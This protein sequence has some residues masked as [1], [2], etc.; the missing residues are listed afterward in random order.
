LKI[1]GQQHGQMRSTGAVLLRA[2]M[3]RSGLALALA[4]LLVPVAV[5]ASSG[6]AGQPAPDFALKNSAGTNLRLS[7]Y[8]GQVVLV[9]FWAQWCNRCTEQLAMLSDLQQRYGDANLRILAVNIDTDDKPAR[10]AAKRLG[11]TILHDAD[12]SVVREYD[13]SVLPFAVLVDPHGTVR[14]V[15]AGYRAEDATT[16]T[17]ELSALISE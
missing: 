12:Q 2:F 11:I 17:D 1:I 7:E 8:R 13:P 4:V 5:P 14:Q 15:Y 10:D 6:L 9:S 16:Y 3:R